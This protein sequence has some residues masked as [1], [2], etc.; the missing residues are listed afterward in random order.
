MNII[1][2]NI[3]IF[4]IGLLLVI[5][6]GDMFVDAATW[7]A[8]VLNIPNFI[9]GATVVS[10]ATTL[11][12]MIISLISAK[13]GVTEMA[14]GNAVGSVTMNTA[15]IMALAFIFMMVNTERKSIGIQSILLILAVMVTYL[16]SENGVLGVIPSLI[17]LIIFIVFIIS[18]IKIGKKEK[19]I[20]YPEEEI[21]INT[22]EK[23]IQS[24]KFIV[25]FLMIYGGS[26]LLINS[27]TELAKIMGISDRIIA[28]TLL[29]IGTSLPEL[30]TAI[31]AIRKNNADLSIGNIVGANVIDIAL[32]LPLC[33]IISGSPLSVTSEAISLDLPICLIVTLVALVPCLTRQKASKLQGISLI[34]I[35]AVYLIKL[36]GA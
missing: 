32:I 25:S 29:A 2:V 3:A 24:I 36:I 15:I 16:G 8:R 35:Y 33:S 31:T 19:N 11:P 5:K 21:T 12:E 27:S 6:G 9:I 23:I 14:I 28:L 34:S 30:V 20:E 10:I 18:N 17:L 22:K 7:I 26:Q 4:I 1:V 13:N